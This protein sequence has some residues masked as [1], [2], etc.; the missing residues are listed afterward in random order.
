VG[1]VEHQPQR[2]FQVALADEVVQCFRGGSSARRKWD[3]LFC[4]VVIIDIPPYWDYFRTTTV[5]SRARE[6]SLTPVGR[7]GQWRPYPGGIAIDGDGGSVAR[8]RTV[9]RYE[10]AGLY[11]LMCWDLSEHMIYDFLESL[12]FRCFLSSCALIFFVRIVVYY[13]VHV[14]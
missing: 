7:S 1:G 12:N 13:C 4:W 11:L 6:V 10:L 5:V 9:V 8:F 2:L 14:M 3:C